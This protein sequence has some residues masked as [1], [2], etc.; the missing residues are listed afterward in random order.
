MILCVALKATAAI[1][2]P[3][4]IDKV[5]AVVNNGVVLESDVDD[6]MRTVKTQAKEA[7]QQLPDDQTLHHQI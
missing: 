7:G 1:A 6:M 5:A 3:Q 4:M 2:A